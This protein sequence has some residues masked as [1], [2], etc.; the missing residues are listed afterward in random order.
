MF[1]Y[2]FPNLLLPLHFSTTELCPQE[3]RLYKIQLIVNLLR[4]RSNW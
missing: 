1:R 2:T 3:D 4:E